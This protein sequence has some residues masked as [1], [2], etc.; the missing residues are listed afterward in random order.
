MQW[1]KY[2]ILYSSVIWKGDYTIIM[3]FEVDY[4]KN[5]HDNLHFFF[6]FEGKKKCYQIQEE[7]SIPGRWY[8]IST[9][10]NIIVN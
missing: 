4:K 10:S 8:T 9:S 3:S 5:L 2:S 7:L 6:S 1:L